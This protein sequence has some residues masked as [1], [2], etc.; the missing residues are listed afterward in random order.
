MIFNHLAGQ[1]DDT[2]N[3]HSKLELGCVCYEVASV[4]LGT[5][6]LF[7]TWISLLISLVPG[8]IYMP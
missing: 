3:C 6:K 5:L 7:R 4:S 2:L 1:I 8:P